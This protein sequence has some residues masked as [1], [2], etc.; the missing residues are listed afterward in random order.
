[1]YR[2]SIDQ[3][4]WIL[5]FSP[6]V[7]V[8]KEVQLMIVNWIIQLGNL[9]PSYPHGESF[10]IKSKEEGMVVF[11]VERVPS[12]ILTVLTIVPVDKW[13]IQEEKLIHKWLG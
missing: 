8:P 6:T 13:F 10:L 4:D 12:L 5:R 2:F 3:E 1:M 9:L 7:D 11:H